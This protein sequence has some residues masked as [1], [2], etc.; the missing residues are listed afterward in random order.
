MAGGNVPTT[1]KAFQSRLSGAAASASPG[2][3]PK[4]KR[5]KES[6]K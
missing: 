1:L 4:D 3:S 5:V 2:P 6:F